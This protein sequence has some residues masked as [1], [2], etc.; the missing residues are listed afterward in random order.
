MIGLMC[1]PSSLNSNP[2]WPKLTFFSALANS[3]VL[4]GQPRQCYRRQ[5][6]HN[7]HSKDPMTSRVTYLTNA[8]PKRVIQ[9]DEVR[10]SVKE[11][12]GIK[13]LI[14]KI[15]IILLWNW[16]RLKKKFL[17]VQRKATS[18]SPNDRFWWSGKKT[19]FAQIRGKI[20]LPL[21]FW[22]Q[23]HLWL[24]NDADEVDLLPWNSLNHF[25]KKWVSRLEFWRGGW[26][27]IT[28]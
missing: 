5:N 28:V 15:S 20:F 4:A 23:W 22:C 6:T 19:H 7:V 26:H 17:H 3:H 11:K 27:Y 8:V 16:A 10:F 24:L 2:F 18:H 9:S 12:L 13:S 14:H 21:F 1:L 25:S